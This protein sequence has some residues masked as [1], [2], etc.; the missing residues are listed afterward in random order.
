MSNVHEKKAKGRLNMLIN[1]DNSGGSLSD[2]GSSLPDPKYK[3]G[4]QV[5]EENSCMNKTKQNKWIIL[6][7]LLAMIVALILAIILS[8][9]SG[10]S[11]GPE[12]GPNP[13]PPPTP[14]IPPIYGYW[15]PYIIDVVHT[16]VQEHQIY[17]S[18]KLDP[19]VKLEGNMPRTDDDNSTIKTDPRT[20][21]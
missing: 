21:P 15:N 17:G 20:I 6:S 19:N 8:G 3:M 2:N 13:G 14:P 16:A 10:D 5:D 4:Y 11:P 1:S 9:K 7:I 12:P 18:L